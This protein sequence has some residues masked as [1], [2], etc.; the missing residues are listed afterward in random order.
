MNLQQFT[1]K[2]NGKYVD[3]DGY[4]GAQCVDL[5]QFW[6]K[7][8]GGPRFSGNAADIAGQTGGFYTWHTSGVPSPG[9]IVVFKR[10]PANGNA[11]HIAIVLDADSRGIT[12][13]D[14]NYP[15]GSPTRTN[16]HTYAKVLGWLTPPGGNIA[17]SQDQYNQLS[18]SN[19]ENKVQAIQ[20]YIFGI[21]ENLHDKKDV[22]KNHLGKEAVF[23]QK[24]KDDL[25]NKFLESDPQ[26]WIDAATKAYT[27]MYGK[28]DYKA[29][30]E[31]KRKARITIPNLRIEMMKNNKK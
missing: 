6:S 14:Q 18:T 15:T 11:G 12:T 21:T 8:L 29:E 13:L 1:N 20:G 7:E 19:H 3:F 10:E 22:E 16:R 24:E 2:Y 4:Y 25:F 30:V 28:G 17:Y 31:K 26:E 9:S 5:V 23:T 27:D